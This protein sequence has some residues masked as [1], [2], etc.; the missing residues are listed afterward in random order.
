MN[1][2]AKAIGGAA[3]VAIAALGL[4]GCSAGDETLEVLVSSQRGAGSTGLSDGLY[5]RVTNSSYPPVEG[6][7]VDV[8]DETGTIL[9]TGRFSEGVMADNQ[10]TWSVS[11]GGIP[12][13]RNI[14]VISTAGYGEAKYTKEE[15]DA[16]DWNLDLC[17][18]CGS[19]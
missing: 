1:R 18:D 6:A 19:G 4:S 5:C 11:L 13:D 12:A 16:S 17:M 8:L 15:L 10:C 2:R 7:A 9:G 3:L 14:Y